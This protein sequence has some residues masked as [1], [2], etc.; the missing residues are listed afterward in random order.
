MSSNSPL[1]FTSSVFWYLFFWCFTLTGDAHFRYW[2]GTSQASSLTKLNEHSNT[3]SQMLTFSHLLH[4]TFFSKSYYLSQHTNT[5]DTEEASLRFRINTSISIWNTE[6]LNILEHNQYTIFH[7]AQ[8][9]IQ[10]PFQ[11]SQYEIF[12]QLQ[13][14]KNSARDLKAKM[15][16]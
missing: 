5:Q 14:M 2:R 13:Q 6:I 16:T 11:Y 4:I 7:L 9:H 10:L 8:L 3:D 12:Y 1:I 15:G